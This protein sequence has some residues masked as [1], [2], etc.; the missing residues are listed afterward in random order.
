[1]E[2]SPRWAELLLPAR[3]RRLR[4]LEIGVVHANAVGDGEDARLFQLLIVG[5]EY[6]AIGDERVLHVAIVVERA[7]VFDGLIRA[8]RRL[9][10]FER[11]DVAR[12]GADEVARGV[13]VFVCQ[14]ND[15]E[16]YVL[17]FVLADE[18]QGRAVLFVAEQRINV[19]ARAREETGGSLLPGREGRAV[20]D[21]PD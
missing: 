3:G 18:G 16:V 21:A 17:L 11:K 13:L 2:M 19:V 15:P 14:I 6:P 7:P 8:G 20:D 1:M 4:V 5:V 10:V 12:L 9:F